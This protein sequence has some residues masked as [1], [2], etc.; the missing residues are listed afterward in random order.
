MC[1]SIILF[2]LL[3][4]G[5]SAGPIT[6]LRLDNGAMVRSEVLFAD[7]NYLYCQKV[8]DRTQF[9]YALEDAPLALRRRVEYLVKKGELTAPTN[10]NPPPAK[11]KKAPLSL[12]QYSE[13][14]A[15]GTGLL[16]K[17]LTL[18]GTCNYR[19]KP[20]INFRH[21]KSRYEAYI[22]FDRKISGAHKWLITFE[23]DEEPAFKEGW[24]VSTSG[25]AA[26]TLGAI[27]F[28][29][30]LKGHGT[31]KISTVD[32]RGENLVVVFKVAGFESEL[33]KL[34]ASLDL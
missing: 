34:E 5:A 2:L 33:Q 14:R 13:S 12:W 21:Y 22:Y 28:R 23:I 9:T 6:T 8:T 1:R 20:S 25:E 26:F 18:P 7:S 31:L 15:P 27:S 10:A 30:R 29:D 19:G 24:S 3:T 4:A 32:Y 17:N 11:L 16:V